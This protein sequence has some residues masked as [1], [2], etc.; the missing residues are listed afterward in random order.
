MKFEFKVE[1]VITDMR[2]R[3]F[4][5]CVILTTPT[6]SIAHARRGQT[7]NEAISLAV[8]FAMDRLVLPET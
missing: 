6:Q 3:G 4:E 8:G 7:P 2:D 1:A 5:A